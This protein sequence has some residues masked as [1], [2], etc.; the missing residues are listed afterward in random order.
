MRI[1][2]E[3]TSRLS[4]PPL[5]CGSAGL[6]AQFQQLLPRPVSVTPEPEV[7]VNHVVVAVG[8]QQDTSALQTAALHREF[9][10]MEGIGGQD[11]AKTVLQLHESSEDNKVTLFTASVGSNPSAARMEESIEG[12]CSAVVAHIDTLCGLAQS[13]QLPLFGLVAT[14]GWTLVRILGHLGVE[15]ITIREAISNT[16]ALCE[17]EGGKLRRFWLVTK[18]GAL[19]G[20]DE[21]VKSAYRMLR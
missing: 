10:L 9:S 11:E 18:G 7:H 4:V 6:A 5:L 2:A 21:F 8:S 12:L 14:G 20:E 1:I 16:S 13:V 3:A 19:G 15:R 17:A